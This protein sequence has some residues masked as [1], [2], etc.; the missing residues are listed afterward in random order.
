MPVKK[1]LISGS[2]FFK[3]QEEKEAQIQVK[4]KEQK[5]LVDSYTEG[6]RK[7]ATLKVT[8]NVLT[9]T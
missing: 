9:D 7:Q 4:L 3:K 6:Q 5:D 2:N 8:M 1:C